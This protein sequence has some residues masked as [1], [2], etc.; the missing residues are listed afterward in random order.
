MPDPK[1]RPRTMVTAAIVKV[2]YDSINEN[3]VKVDAE[4]VA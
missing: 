1:T 4:G 2:D 3:N